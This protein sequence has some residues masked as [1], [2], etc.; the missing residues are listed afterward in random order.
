MLREEDAGGNRSQTLI[1]LVLAGLSLRLSR[2]RK[3][4]QFGI[5]HGYFQHPHLYNTA[6]HTAKQGGVR[7]RMKGMRDTPATSGAQS[8]HGGWEKA[9]GAL[10]DTGQVFSSLDRIG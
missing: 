2:D 8:P 10:E 6:L 5:C 3:V 7:C 9:H 1:S 4:G